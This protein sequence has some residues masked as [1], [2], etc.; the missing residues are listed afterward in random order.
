[1]T[2]AIFINFEVNIFR[3]YDEMRYFAN[4]TSNIAIMS[5]ENSFFSEY[6]LFLLKK[7]I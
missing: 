1:M 6:K 2:G 4:N 3:K 7:V 5:Y